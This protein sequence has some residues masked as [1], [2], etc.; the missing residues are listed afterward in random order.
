MRFSKTLVLAL[1]L[2]LGFS[3]Q[4][5]AIEYDRVDTAKSSIK[6]VPT[7]MG[8]KTEGAF[9]KFTAQVRFD[10]DKPA[11]A[12]AKADVDIRSFDIGYDEATAEALGKNWFDVQQFP[13]AD[14]SVSKVKALGKDRFELTGNLT[15]R[16]KTKALTFPV[17][18]N[19]DTAQTARLDGT[20]V[21]KRLDFNL[22]QGAWSSTGT[23]AN[24]VTLIIR[25]AL[26]GK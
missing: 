5:L 15:I 12:A 6:F 17:T 3:A 19:R 20:V 8:S 23:V 24:D 7:L 1:T 4:S 26:S 18:L 11:N 13:T 10:P 14:F 9:S 21:I 22:G 2:S 25:L 16:G